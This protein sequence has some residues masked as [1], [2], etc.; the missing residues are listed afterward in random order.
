MMSMNKDRGKI[1]YYSGKDQLRLIDL[2]EYEDRLLVEDEFWFRGSTPGFS[3]DGK[4]IYYTAFRHFEQD[5]HVYD[6]QR[7]TSV[8]VTNT[9][10]TEGDPFWSPDGKY[11]YESDN[12]ESGVIYVDTDKQ[13]RLILVDKRNLPEYKMLEDGESIDLV[14][15]DI[16]NNKEW[17]QINYMFYEEGSGK[18]EEY[19]VLY[20]VRSLDR[21]SPDIL[22]EIYG[23]FG[24]V[25]QEGTIYLDTADGQINLNKIKSKISNN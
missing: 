5:I 7:R 19:S 11:I 20:H 4:Y 8:N 13:K 12:S 23:A 25:E 22:K 24:F 14:L 17:A 9:Y 2:E 16:S 18:V 21:V 10:V 1:I 15:M 6:L 3:P